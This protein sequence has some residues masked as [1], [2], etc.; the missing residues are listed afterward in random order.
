MEDG[1]HCRALPDSNVPKIV[2]GQFMHK[3]KCIVHQPKAVFLN[4]NDFKKPPKKVTDENMFFWG[5]EIEVG[6]SI[7]KDCYKKF[8]NRERDQMRQVN[9]LP[10][11]IRV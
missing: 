9:T 7:C 6:G 2:I 1:K 10:N 4:P 8:G 11:K 3:Y 5:Q